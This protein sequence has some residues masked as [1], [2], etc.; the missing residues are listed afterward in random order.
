MLIDLKKYHALIFQ[1]LKSIL[2]LN[3][4]KDLFK[5]TFA[6]VFDFKQVVLYIFT[7]YC[8]T[9]VSL[10]VCLTKCITLCV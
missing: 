9:F 5:N 2:H 10:G 1:V 3:L 7:S 4:H 8:I 6:L